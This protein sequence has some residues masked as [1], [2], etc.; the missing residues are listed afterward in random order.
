ME[1]CNGVMRRHWRPGIH[2]VVIKAVNLLMDLLK[3]TNIVNL[4][5]SKPLSFL[6]RSV[7]TAP[8]HLKN[9]ITIINTVV[10]L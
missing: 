2:G 4:T 1:F 5:I 7:F 6:L 8:S 10:L 3:D 9:P